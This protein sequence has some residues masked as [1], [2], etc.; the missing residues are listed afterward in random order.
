[1]GEIAGIE[2]LAQVKSL[3]RDYLPGFPV[4][5]G[6][7]TTS[8]MAD[9]GDHVDVTTQSTEDILGELLE[10]LDD[11]SA[12]PASPG[13]ALAER[14]RADLSVS[15]TSTFQVLPRETLDGPGRHG[16]GLVRE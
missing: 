12:A 8:S 15:S 14:N 3:G 10:S 11:F 13:P 6:N 16:D 7:L 2:P 5:T 1:M 4:A 9:M